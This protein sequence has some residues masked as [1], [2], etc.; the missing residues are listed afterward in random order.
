M[1]YDY[2]GNLTNGAVEV[3]DASSIAAEGTQDAINTAIEQLK[4]GE[5]KVFNTSKFTVSTEKNN[6][7]VDD[8]KHLTSYKADIDYDEAYTGDTEVI[9]DG[10]FHETEYRSL[11]YFDIIIDGVEEILDNSDNKD[12][13]GTSI[14]GINGSVAAILVIVGV[15]FLCPIFTFP[16]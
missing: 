3:Y 8:N 16:L 9:S 2:V 15:F 4:S 12:L 11:P 14:A 5:I 7:V 13:N 1:D 10:Y 6:M